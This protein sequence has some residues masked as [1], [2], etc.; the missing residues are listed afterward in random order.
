MNSH[1][2]SLRTG[3]WLT[4]PRVHFVPFTPQTQNVNLNRL[5]LLM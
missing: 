1:N 4:R 5:M 2:G 3:Y